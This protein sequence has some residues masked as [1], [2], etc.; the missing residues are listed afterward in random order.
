MLAAYGFVYQ[1][2][3]RYNTRYI[4]LSTGKTVGVCM[5]CIFGY[6]TY[7]LLLL[8]SRFLISYIL[9]TEITAPVSASAQSAA[10]RRTPMHIN[11]KDVF[12]QRK[13]SFFEEV[14]CILH[15]YTR[16]CAA[17]MAVRYAALSACRKVHVCHC[18]SLGG[19]TWR[20][21]TGRTDR[22]TDRRT[23]CDAICGP[24]LG[25]RAA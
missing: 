8:L 1:Y 11:R 18:N 17:E 16:M 6:I 12:L 2:W 20:S 10:G 14:L 22:R 15:N 23:E 13:T 3:A 5:F 25:R 9:T 4:R 21:I 7:Y 19:A 24:L